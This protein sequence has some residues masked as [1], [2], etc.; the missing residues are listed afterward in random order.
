M[1]PNWRPSSSSACRLPTP[2][3]TKPTARPRAGVGWGVPLC[4]L[5]KI[6]RPEGVEPLGQVTKSAIS[7]NVAQV[8]L[9]LLHVRQELLGVLRALAAV[10]GD[11]LQQ[12][13]LDIRSH[14]LGIAADVKVGSVLQPPPQIGAA[15]PHP[16]LDVDL[17]LLV[18]RKGRIQPVENP[19][20]L[21]A[22]QLV[23]VEE[24]LGSPLIAEEEP[25]R[26]A[27]NARFFVL[28]VGAERRDAG[29]RT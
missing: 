26:P 28:D 29:P 15:L 25:H 14:P 13:R 17:L 12:R 27:P 1:C 19:V 8:P 20:L 10:E 11:R 16:V 4:K 9:L 6:K 18:A 5:L 22:Q 2:Q 21:P 7:V 23:P 3:W 24:V